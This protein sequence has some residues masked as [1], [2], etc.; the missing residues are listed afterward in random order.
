MSSLEALP[1]KDIEQCHLF[2]LYQRVVLSVDD[3]YGLGLTHNSIKNSSAYDAHSAER[4]TQTRYLRGLEREVVVVV[5]VVVLKEL[6]FFVTSVIWMRNR[7][8]GSEVTMTPHHF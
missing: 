5:V 6:L 2:L 1:A 8:R 3:G 4:D 7:G